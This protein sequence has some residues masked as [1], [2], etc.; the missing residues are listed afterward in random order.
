MVEQAIARLRALGAEM[1]DDAGLP[2]VSYG[3]ARAYELKHDL[4]T[5]L[6]TFLPHAEVKSLADVIAFNQAHKAQEMSWFGQELFDKAQA[7]EDLDSPAYREALTTCVKGSRSEGLD[8]VS[9]G[10]RS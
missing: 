2:A 8:K 3:D 9:T 6:R 1:I 5:W 7:L 4:G 10:T